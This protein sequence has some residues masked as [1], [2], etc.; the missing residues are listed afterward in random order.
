MYLV[1]VYNGPV[2]VGNTSWYLYIASDDDYNF[3]MMV[4]CC[5]L[6][7]VILDGNLNGLLVE[8]YC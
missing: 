2:V 8:F 6:Y 3:W 4:K 5:N 1:I 7:L